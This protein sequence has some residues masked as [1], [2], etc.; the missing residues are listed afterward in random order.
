MNLTARLHALS[1]ELEV[2]SQSPTPSV[3]VLRQ[4]SAEAR[5]LAGEAASWESKLAAA[6]E[7]AEAL[8]SLMEFWDNGTPVRPGTEVVGEARAALAKA[9]NITT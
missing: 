5:C 2:A 6:P 9:E 1:V 4:A 7:L 8:R 3:I